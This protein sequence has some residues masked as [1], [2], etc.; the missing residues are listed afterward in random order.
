MSNFHITTKHL[1]GLLALVLLT[2]LGF[3]VI[4][5][6]INITFWEYLIIQFIIIGLDRLFIHIRKGL[7]I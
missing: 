6:I 3:F 7:K 4:N 1:E 5:L 2:A